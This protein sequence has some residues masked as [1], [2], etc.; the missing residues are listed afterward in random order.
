M[1]KEAPKPLFEFWKDTA[2]R[3]NVHAYLVEYLKQEGIRMAFDEDLTD[4]KAVIEAKK[5]IDKA[6]ENMN[7]LFEAKKERKN[8]INEAR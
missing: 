1:K 4:M 7:L 5:M 3:D 2:T 8:I 6:F